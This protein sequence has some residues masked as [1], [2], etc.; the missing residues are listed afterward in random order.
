MRRFRGF[1]LIEIL[2]VLAIIAVLAAIIFPVYAS[3]RA[4]AKLTA[5][6]SNLY[7]WGRVEDNTSASDFLHCPYPQGD[8]DGAYIDVSGNY[9]GNDP[10]YEPDAGTVA[11]YCVEHLAKGNDTTFE[12]PLRGKFPVRKF[13]NGTA[14]IDAKAVTRWKKVGKEWTQIDETGTVP[15]YPEIWHFPGDDFPP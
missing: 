9:K 11:T 5:C 2:V 10:N 1:T 15:I 8:D 14:L 3:M 13:G 7:Q 6:E 12:V 4:R